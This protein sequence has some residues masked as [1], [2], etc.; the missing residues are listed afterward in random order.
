VKFKA[1]LILTLLVASLQAADKSIY[2]SLCAEPT[3]NPGIIP[4]VEP[5]EFPTIYVGDSVE[6][7]VNTCDIININ[8]VVIGFVGAGINSMARQADPT[9][10]PG[11]Y[12]S[13]F[14]IQNI[15]VFDLMVRV[16][17]DYGNITE[18][19]RILFFIP[20]DSPP[21]ATIISPTNGGDSPYSLGDTIDIDIIAADSDG[22]VTA[23]EVFTNGQS[24]GLASATTEINT[25]RL[26]YTAN[27]LGLNA[28][29][30]IVTDNSGNTT[31]SS[32]EVITVIAGY[33]PVIV[34]GIEK[35]EVGVNLW[36]NSASSQSHRIESSNDL[37][38]WTIL[39]D[40]IISEGDTVIRYY[41]T[42]GIQKRFYRVKRND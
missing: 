1:L 20:S 34:A 25:F 30:A 40:E 29:S 41:D 3:G 14:S 32:V 42:V 19:E 11:H 27:T 13:T 16:T 38:N 7:I 36:F 5:P 15:G 31:N 22:N 9:G 33:L 2:I 26:S 8:S 17:D 21:T 37:E 23:V 6:I 39:E 18:L 10:I 35:L 4:P 12:S 24:L 28:L